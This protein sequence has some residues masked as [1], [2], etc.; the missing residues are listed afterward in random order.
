LTGFS[1]C[2]AA[3]VGI[4]AAVTAAAA[5]TPRRMKL[6]RFDGLMVPP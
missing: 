6:R 4:V 1:V 5:V 2:A 3:V